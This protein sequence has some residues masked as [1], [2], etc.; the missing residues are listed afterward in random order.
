[1]RSVRLNVVVLVVG[2]V[3]DCWLLLLV[4]VVVLLLLPPLLLRDTLIFP[5]VLELWVADL[6]EKN[7]ILL[8]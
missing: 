2:G 6:N 5:G 7:Q 1:M 3:G 8:I 4:A